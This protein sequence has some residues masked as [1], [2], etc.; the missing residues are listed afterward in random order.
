MI[1]TVYYTKKN[2]FMNFR[3]TSNLVRKN[4][5]G[6]V[7]SSSSNKKTSVPGSFQ[8]YVPKKHYKKQTLQI[9]MGQDELNKLV[10]ELNWYDDK[11]QLIETAPLNNSAASF[12]IHENC[13]IT[14]E[15]DG[16]S[17]DDEL[18][19]DRFWLAC[20]RADK[21]FRFKGDKVSPS[22]ANRVRYTVMELGESVNEGVNKA[23]EG[24]LA[25]R[26]LENLSD[27]QRVMVLRAMGVS[28]T[29]D[30]DRSDKDAVD[31]FN[32]SVFGALYERITDNKDQVINGERNIDTFMRLSTDKTNS[33]E[34]RA[35]IRAAR[36]NG[37]IFKTRS[38]EYKFGEIK[39]GSSI[40]SCIEFLQK[41]ENK[42]VFQGIVEKME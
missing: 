6:D 31:R 20:F 21:S 10:A 19:L 3:D 39:L 2:P 11:G 17:F 16:M 25:F 24:I 8:R 28:V 5:E 14:I 32:K 33:T 22:V 26:T 7:V 1:Y 41:D 12:W 13:S 27:K 4:K 30:H 37:V 9:D 34:I 15:N 36:D 42:D 38:N 35:I 29:E 18:P 40:A 23:Q